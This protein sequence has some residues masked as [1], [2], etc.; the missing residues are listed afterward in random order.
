M[1]K[2]AFLTSLARQRSITTRE[3]LL[4]AF[5]L[6]TAAIITL[7]LSIKNYRAANTSLSLLHTKIAS[8]QKELAGKTAI[9]ARLSAHTKRLEPAAAL[10][11]SSFQEIIERAARQARLL[12]SSVLPSNKTENGIQTISLRLTFAETTMERLLV[13]EDLLRAQKI[14]LTT[15]SSRIEPTIRDGEIR[16]TCEIAIHRLDTTKN[17]SPARPTSARS[18]AAR[19]STPTKRPASLAS[20]TKEPL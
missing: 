17:D 12:P 11:P 4:L 16:V 6:I 10:H 7:S 14:P 13:F 5:V 19:S 15:L 20:A 1:K 2:I 18:S 8:R 3:R 9:E